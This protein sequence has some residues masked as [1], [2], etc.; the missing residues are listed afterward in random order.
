MHRF[1]RVRLMVL[2]IA[3]AALAALAGPGSAA[4]PGLQFDPAVRL[5]HPNLGGYEPG[6][7]VDRF[8]NI[9]ITA[10]K[11]NHID[12]LAPDPASPT[13]VR[14]ASWLWTSTDGVNFTDL[15]GLSALSL[16]NMN[17]G[18]EGDIALDQADNLYFVDTDVKDVT[19]SRWHI[20]GL[21]RQ[22]YQT[23]PPVIGGAQALADRPWIA[24]LGNGVV[25]YFANEG[26][27]DSNPAGYAQHRGPANGPGRYTVYMSYDHGTTWDH[28]G[29]ELADSGWCRPAADHAP[30]SQTFYVVCT[31]DSGADDN[32][33]NPGDAGYTVGTFYAY[34]T[35]D[36]GH[37]WSRYVVGHYDG[38]TVGTWPTVMVDR[39]GT[40]YV[41]AVDPHRT[42]HQP[43]QD[44]LDL[45][46]SHSHGRTW[47]RRVL[48]TVGTELPYTA[49]A[50][51]PDGTLGITYYGRPAK[52]SWWY[53]YAGELRGNGPYSSSKVSP[54][55]I[56]DP[57]ITPWGDFYQAAF[58]PGD[59]LYVTWT[60]NANLE[61]VAQTSGLNSD[62]YFA[63]QR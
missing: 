12:A 10:H 47:T 3:G 24:A 9:Y 40:V 59:K 46:I 45:F 61:G 42:P 14:S 39:R 20:S 56:A 29:Y 1:T 52:N 17:V 54:V 6:I 48:P 32:V 18:D 28:T 49:L 51:A 5:T 19:F 11:Q 43:V 4:S 55:P 31:N 37:S 38:H 50:V 63:R 33:H 7:Q 53:L 16:N 36:A 34:V 44:V 2:G 8:G 26:D 27:K 25:G 13:G 23:E 60:V 22:T 15:P 35:Q 58:G 21:G 57:S 30:G 41:L 62:I